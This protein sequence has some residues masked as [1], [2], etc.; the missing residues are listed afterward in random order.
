VDLYNGAVNLMSDNDDDTEVQS[1][2]VVYKYYKV[3][4]GIASVI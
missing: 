2:Q 4:H 3:L 1:V